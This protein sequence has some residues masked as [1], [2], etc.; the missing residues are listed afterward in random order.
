V[1]CF[2]SQVARLLGGEDTADYDCVV[3][4]GGPGGYVAAIRLAQ[5]KQKVVVVDRDRL[6]GVC[7][8]YGCIPSK[9]LIHAAHVFESAGHS[10]EL[11]IRAGSVSLDV[12]KLQAWKG[13]VVSKLTG[14]VAQLL[15][16][17]GAEALIGE[18]TIVSP[19]VVKVK[20]KDGAKDLT[21]RAVIVATGARAI[22]LPFAR[23]DRETIISSKEALELK[24]IPKSMVVIGGGIIGL[25]IASFLAKFGT[26]ITVVEMLEEVLPGVDVD[27]TRVV[28]KNL[29]AHGVEFFT[30]AAAKNVEKTKGGAKVTFTTEEGETKVVE[31]EKVLVSVG[32]RPNV[33]GFGLEA[34]GVKRAEKGGWILVDDRQSTNVKGIYAIGDCTGPPYLAH[35]ASKQGIVAA[36]VIAGL[37]SASDFRAMPGAIFTDPE[38][39]TVGLTEEQAKA[40]GV[41]YFVGKV[42]FGAV[43]KSIAMN[44]P[45]GFVKLLFDKGTKAIVGAHI[46]GAGASEL[47]SELALALELGATAEDIALT[48]HPHPTMPEGIMEA[49]EAA[50]GHSIHFMG[51]RR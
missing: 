26:K 46:V 9:A 16:G 45:D 21:T 35:R 24:A 10:E 39:A 12:E 31:V 50:L 19:T 47:I 14:G 11:G 23:F 33:E 36:E 20:T 2:G 49:A 13:T 1:E 6:G 28:K 40:Q 30:K 22:D 4:G 18:A 51:A 41:E 15:K 17:N 37:P 29:R 42:P 25:E 27:C 48:V 34:P 38:I 44:A 32:L 43:G 5:L 7:L 8:N 3:I